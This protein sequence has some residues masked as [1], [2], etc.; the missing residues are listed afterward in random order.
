LQQVDEL[1]GVLLLRGEDDRFDSSTIIADW[2]TEFFG[3]VSVKSAASCAEALNAIS[4]SC[5]ELVLATH[6]MPTTNGIGLAGV[7][8]TRPNPPVVVVIGTNSDAELETQCAAAGA[9]FCLEKRHLQ[10]RLLQ[11]RFAQA[12]AEGVR[13]RRMSARSEPARLAGRHRAYGI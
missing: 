11:Q 7:I 13:A 12:W 1:V 9:D 3:A 4:R 8:E 2:L 6:R 5:P 10:A